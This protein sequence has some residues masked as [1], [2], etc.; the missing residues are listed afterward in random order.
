MKPE[1]FIH[2]GYPK[3]ASTFLQ[4]NVFPFLKDVHFIHKYMK[5]LYGVDHPHFVSM[6]R[7]L[8][9]KNLISSEILTGGF[10]I[11]D[12]YCDGKEMLERLKRLYP[13]A[14]IIII[15]RNRDDWL[16][17]MY[18]QFMA[19]PFQNRHCR[20]YDA[21]YVSHL[22]HELLDVE[23]YIKKAQ[24][25]FSRVLVIPFEQFREDNDWGVDEICRFMD[26]ESLKNYKKGREMVRLNS[27]QLGL[28]RLFSRLGF[29]SFANRYVLGVMR[30]L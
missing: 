5:N 23:G 1:V 18:Q 29:P 25:L 2:V 4:K 28:I 3:C 6:C 21:W 16:Q 12:F 13:D 9:G 19:N 11:H 8:P 14:G 10:S 17:S 15:Y 26:V 27:R 7:L 30:R 22:K 20:N 24:E